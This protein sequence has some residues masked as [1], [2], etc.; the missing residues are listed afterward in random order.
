MKNDFTV[1]SVMIVAACVQAVCAQGP[2]AQIQQATMPSPPEG[3]VGVVTPLFFWQAP[4]ESVGHRM[5]LGQ[6]AENLPWVAELA[7]HETFYYHIAGL[8]GGHTYYWRVDEL[9][10]DGSIV[11]GSLWSFM[12]QGLAACGPLPED[13]TPYASD[14]SQLLWMPG[15][16]AFEQDIYLGT[17]SLIVAFADTSCPEYLQT[18]DGL[19]SSIDPGKLKHNTTYY[20]RVDTIEWD[21]SW[22]PGPVWSFTTWPEVSIVDPNLVAWWQC[23]EGM[24]S[25]CLDSSGHER[26]ASLSHCGWTDGRSGLGL[27]F[28]GIS[29]QMQAPGQGLPVGNSIFT[30]ATWMRPET[31][32]RPQGLLAWGSDNVVLENRLELVGQTLR[33]RLGASTFDTHLGEIAEEW[34]HVLLMHLGMGIRRVYVNGALQNGVAESPSQPRVLQ[35]PITVGSRPWPYTDWVFNGALD[36]IRIYDR[37]VDIGE[38]QDMLLSNPEMASNPQPHDRKQISLNDQISLSWQSSPQALDNEIYLGI[39]RGQVQNADR[40]STGIY[41]GVQNV[42]T[43]VPPETFTLGQTYYWRVDQ[44]FSGPTIVKGDVWRFA[45]ADFQVIDDFESYTDIPA[46]AVFVTWVDGHGYDTPWPGMEG[47]GSQATVGHWEKPYAEEVIVHSGGQSMPLYFDNQEMPCYSETQRR[48]DQ[49]ALDLA[50][51]GVRYL[52][53]HFRGHPDNEVAAT[54]RLYLTLIDAAGTEA[55]V[56][57]EGTDEVL[58]STQWQRWSIFLQ[59]ISGQGLDVHHVVSITLG[60]GDRVTPQAGGTGLIFVDDIL[61]TVSE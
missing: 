22:Y 34:T 10:T 55:N 2:D 56:I 5:F 7:A 8:A 59:P 11:T 32:D 1:C 16:T 52:M 48:F 12:T 18:T 30:L 33:H 29:S 14:R 24:G 41:R 44:R 38:I 6:D 36:D 40:N 9:L 17:D 15:L 57:Y 27:T 21:G 23:D 47:N 42:S 26:H 46:N 50:S 39:D 3:A 35:S 25:T 53:V 45:I 31:A 28:D 20:W 4:A 43:Y 49:P 58:Q 13:G 61:L 60:I 19:T 51:H 37:L 54:D